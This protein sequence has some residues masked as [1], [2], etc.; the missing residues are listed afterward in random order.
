MRAR[1]LKY[2]RNKKCMKQILMS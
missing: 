2:E 1:M